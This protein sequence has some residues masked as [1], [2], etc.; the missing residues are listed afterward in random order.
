MA[1]VGT[2]VLILMN[3]TKNSG[4]AKYRDIGKWLDE[5]L[6]E[7]DAILIW[8]VQVEKTIIENW[9]VNGRTLLAQRFSEGGWELFVPAANSIKAERSLRSAE[10]FCGLRDTSEINE[11]LRASFS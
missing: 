3:M 1:Y 9:R 4:R 6:E 11:L 2:G 5:W 10:I 7:V 8:S